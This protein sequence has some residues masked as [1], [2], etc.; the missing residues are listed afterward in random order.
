M[1]SWVIPTDE[2][3][4]IAIVPFLSCSGLNPKIHRGQTAPGFVGGAILALRKY[5]WESR[6]KLLVS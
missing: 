3:L 5:F 2:H 6:H 1:M 4:A